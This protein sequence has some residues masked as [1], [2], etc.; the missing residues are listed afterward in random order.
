M[1]FHDLFKAWRGEGILSETLDQFTKMIDDTRW[2]F[3]TANTAL[4]EKPDDGSKK[5]EI[6]E[7]D[8]LVNKSERSIRKKI[9]QHLAINPG[10]DVNYCL[11][12]MSVV[13][14]AERLGDYAKNLI[15]VAEYHDTSKDDNDLAPDLKTA[16][17]EVETLFLEVGT[18]FRTSDQAVAE[19]LVK[20]EVGLAKR[21]DQILDRILKSTGLTVPQAVTYALLARHYKRLAAHLGNIASSVIMPIHKLDYFDEGYIGEGGKKEG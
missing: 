15:E 16:R 11:I 14:D 6:R 12:L 17:D 7:R 21:L 19:R 3:E 10:S 4:W 9:V 20:N 18:T 13:K 8:I 1:S 2:M 5:K